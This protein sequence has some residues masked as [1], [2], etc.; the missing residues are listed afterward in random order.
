MFKVIKDAN[1]AHNACLGY[2]D[3]RSVA[4][5]TE[6]TG[7]D[8]HTDKVILLSISSKNK[9][10]CVVDTRDVRCLDAFGDLLKSES[11]IKVAHNGIFDYQMIKGTCGIETENIICTQLGEQT[12]TVGMQFD[13]YSLEAITEKYLG[14][15]R[16]KTLQK[17]F[18]GHTGEFTADQLSY[19][20]E[21]TSLLPDI[22]ARINDKARSLGLVKTWQIE[23]GV[24]QCFGDIEYY[25]QLIS[26][27][28]W[29]AV[30]DENSRRAKSAKKE[31]DAWFRPVC[32]LMFDLEGESED[33]YVIDMNYES[34]PTMLHKLRMLG[35][36]VDGELI[37]NTN[38]KTQK[39]LQEHPIMVLLA[40]YRT[41][42]HGI[43]QFGQ[44]YL[45]RIHPKTGR[46]HFRFNQYGTETGRT[47]CRGKLN[48]LNIPRE[49]RYRECFTTDPDRLISTVDYSGAELRI[50]AELSG[51]PLMVQGF[52]SGVDFHCFV[53]S[54]LFNKEVTKK[55]ENKHLRTPTKELSFGL[56]YG[57][58]PPS[59]CEKL[60][61]NGHKITLDECR[62]LF[63]K[64][65]NTFE[66]TI[67]WLKS[68]QREASTRLVMHNMNGRTRNFFKP[69]PAKAREKLEMELRKKKIWDGLSEYQIRAMVRDKIKAQ[70]AAIEREGANFQIQSVNADFTKTAMARCRK[71]YKRRGWDVRS[72]NTVYDEIVDDM[73]KS[74]AEEAHELKQKIMIAA[75]NEM[76]KKVPMEV[77]GHLSSVW[78]K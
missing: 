50:M 3:S 24:V 49:T 29:Q 18:I 1:T 61:G 19:A 44:S 59:L 9:G 12:L 68:Q 23:S 26:R 74:C 78:Q 39:K 32:D 62:D 34:Q 10:T 75:A 7:L 48:C 38:K 5:D 40:K 36:A 71:E 22:C 52:N 64:Y 53:A 54:M 72:Y 14:I 30:M 27:E 66:T 20:A 15:K 13:G 57:M 56:A 43:K 41:A 8:P 58:S 70:T 33:G 67:K 46:V 60:N 21:D 28:K 63:D 77:E 2:L 4:I 35:V 31:L 17:S 45:D 65:M 37:T 11:V 6:T 69:D 55:N 73:H 25:G 47:A 42:K 16:D 51:D 76:L